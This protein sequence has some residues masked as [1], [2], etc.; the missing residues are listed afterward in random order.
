MSNPDNYYAEPKY[1]PKPNLFFQSI[2]FL[3]GGALPNIP[4]P[5]IRVCENWRQAVDYVLE[6][7]FR[8]HQSGFTLEK[9]EAPGE[10]KVLTPGSTVRMPA[11]EAV[12][13]LE[14]VEFDGSQES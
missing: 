14:A 12:N 13:F 4:I 11:D 2:P 10:I 7:G 9:G 5:E 8:Y 1:F 3:E 6:T